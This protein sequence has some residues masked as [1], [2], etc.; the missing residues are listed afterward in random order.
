MQWKAIPGEKG[1]WKK[2][3]PYIMV[4][5]PLLYCQ[6]AS[7]ARLFAYYHYLVAFCS[8]AKSD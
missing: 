6:S 5:E 1:N 3:K 7:L 2:P 4:G 8:P